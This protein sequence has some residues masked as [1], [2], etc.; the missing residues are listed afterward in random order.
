MPQVKLLLNNMFI[1]KKAKNTKEMYEMHMIDEYFYL[2]GMMNI[3]IL[4][5][6]V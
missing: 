5:G 2:S 6:P 1:L 3:F 4:V